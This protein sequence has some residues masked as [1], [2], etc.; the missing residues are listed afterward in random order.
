M[1]LST[2]QA[3]QHREEARKQKSSSRVRLV[4]DVQLMLSIS[5]DSLLSQRERKAII[6]AQLALSKK[7]KSKQRKE[8]RKTKGKTD[9]SHAEAT[10]STKRQITK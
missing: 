2:Q 8:Q 9:V 10:N 1:T 5:H 3:A 4:S 7:E 6:A